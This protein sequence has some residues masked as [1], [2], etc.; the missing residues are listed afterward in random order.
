M[1][2]KVATIGEVYN[3]LAG[4]G[5]EKPTKEQKEA[6]PLARF[7]KEWG[8]LSTEDQQQIKAGI[9]DGSFNY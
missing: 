4:D 3:F 8:E 9:G 5:K 7:R 1:A 6:Y 2:E